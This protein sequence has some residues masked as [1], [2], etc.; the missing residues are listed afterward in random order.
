M[1]PPP[2]ANPDEPRH[3]TLSARQAQLARLTGGSPA[4][5]E[6]VQRFQAASFVAQARSPSVSPAP[7]VVPKPQPQPAAPLKG[8]ASVPALPQAKAVWL[9][10]PTTTPP[11]PT[12]PGAA[13]AVPVGRDPSTDQRRCLAR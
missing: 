3:V 1:P 9:D 12:P 7:R 11:A 10:E 13:A 8:A 6:L 2:E 5:H 4:P